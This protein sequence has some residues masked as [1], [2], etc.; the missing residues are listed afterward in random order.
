MYIVARMRAYEE[1]YSGSAS[2]AERV[3]GRRPSS[4]PSALS[5]SIPR[6]RSSPAPLT[7]AARANTLSAASGSPY[8]MSEAHRICSGGTSESRLSWS[9]GVQVELSKKM[10]STLRASL[11]MPACAT[12][13]ACA[14]ISEASGCRSATCPSSSG[15]P[16]G[17]P[18]PAWMST[19][20]RRSCASAKTASRLRIVD[21]EGL[22]SRVQLD[23]ARAEIEAALGL[24][25]G[26]LVEAQPHER[27]EPVGRL[28][29]PREHAIV[30]RAVGRLAIGLVEREDVRAAHA[31]LVHRARDAP[32]RTACG[33]PRRARDACARRTARSPRAAS[34][35]RC[36]PCA[37]SSSSARSIK[38]TSDT[39]GAYTLSPW[40]KPRH[41]EP[42]R[43]RIRSDAPRRAAERRS[44]ACSSSTASTPSSAFR[45]CTRSRSTAASPRRRSATSRRVTSRARRSWPTATPASRASPASA[46]LITGAGL[47]NAAT[48]IASAYHD[49]IPLLVVSSATARADNGRGHGTLHDLPDQ[50]AFM[51]TIT[52]ESIDVRD[53]ADLPEAF[54]RAFEIFESRRPRP[55]HIGI[56]IDVLDLP[57]SG[58]G[59][60]ARARHAAPS[61]TPRWSSTRSSCWPRP[62]ARCCCSAAAP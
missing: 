16:G 6:R 54:A 33:R 36:A 20:K 15:M 27:E 47:T 42:L 24:A 30:R 61:P 19:G 17:R 48:P 1:R 46:C 26:I 62:S 23:A 59:A 5:R 58:L 12:I 51:A 55:V 22:R 25:E 18:R 29:R 53:P 50:R 14:R 57:G 49:S 3:A 43:P 9:S 44:S 8:G 13:A 11:P 34:R 31:G 28:G 10:F 7:R 21:A 60:A 4:R 32:R 35:R 45:A 40:P 52:A 56:P 38:A 2:G 37:A 41:L 39:S